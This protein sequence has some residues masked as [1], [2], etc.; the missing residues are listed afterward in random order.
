M[1][2]ATSRRPVRYR[3]H[4]PRP[5]LSNNSTIWAVPANFP[6]PTN[7][8]ARATS[9]ERV[10]RVMSRPL[11]EAAGSVFVVIIRF[12]SSPSKIFIDLNIL[13]VN[14][15]MQEA[16]ERTQRNARH[17]WGPC[18]VGAREGLS[19]LGGP[20]RGELEPERRRPRRLRFPCAR[21]AAPQGTVASQ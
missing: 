19:C 4:W 16:A 10:H 6:P 8:N 7:A 17:I 3:N 5:T 21:S 2:P 20:C 1:P 9:P 13:D 11:P 15:K 12:L 14:G 18:L